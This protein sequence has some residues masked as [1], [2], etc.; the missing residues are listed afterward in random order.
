M[1][2][3]FCQ[4]LHNSTYWF[5]LRSSKKIYTSCPLINSLT[6]YFCRKKP[7]GVS[8]EE[9]NK[10][11]ISLDFYVSRDK[12]NVPKLIPPKSLGL[13]SR[14]LFFCSRGVL[15]MLNFPHE[16]KMGILNMESPSNLME[17]WFNFNNFI[18]FHVV[19][20]PR[21]LDPTPKLEPTSRKWVRL[22]QICIRGIVWYNLHIKIMVEGQTI[23]NKSYKKYS[24]SIYMCSNHVVMHIPSLHFLRGQ[25]E[26]Q[27]SHYV[28]GH[29]RPF[30]QLFS[31]F[32]S[33]LSLATSIGL[34][35]T[36][37]SQ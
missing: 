23:W 35:T 9:S 20:L 19:S 4:I 11:T 17:W 32:P 30:H 27:V 13:V 12:K 37:G 6:L 8:E 5:L 24:S 1:H 2:F 25:H 31:P 10:I 14:K 21:I 28:Q 15:H 18:F 22:I 7:S 36:Q 33:H 26:S 3:R 16:K 34:L 29:I